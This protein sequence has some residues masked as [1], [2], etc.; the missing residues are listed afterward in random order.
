MSILRSVL[1]EI[2][3]EPGASVGMV[4]VVGSDWSDEARREVYWELRD[5]GR[6]VYALDVHL[7]GEVYQRP[8]FQDDQR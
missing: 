4:R 6:E 2:E 5:A 7:G 8:Y 3:R 1:I